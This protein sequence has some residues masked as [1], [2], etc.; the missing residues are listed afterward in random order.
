MKDTLPPYSVADGLRVDSRHRYT[1]RRSRALRLLAFGCLAFVAYT[2]WFQLRRD[3]WSPES[4]PV[5]L[6]LERLQ[7]DVATCSKLRHK[8]ADPSGPRDRNARYVDGHDP[9]LIRNATVWVGEPIQ[10]TTVEEARL[11]KG[12]GW[13]KSDILLQNGLILR[14]EP[15]ILENGLPTGTQIWNAYGRQLTAGIV[16][17]HSHTGLFTLPSLRGDSDVNELSNDITPF[18]RAIDALNPLDPQLEVIKSGGVTTSLVLPGSGNNIGGEAYIIKHAVGPKDGRPEISAKDLLADPE[19]NWRYMKMACGE[20]PKGVY[21]ERGH[22]HGPFSRLGESWYFRHAF[23]EAREL[24]HAQDDW[25]NAAHETGV[26]NLK[27]YLPQ[28]LRLESLGAVLRGQV[29]VNTHCYTIPDIEA[30]IDHTNEFEFP[31]R[32]FHHA[33]Q[34]YL[35]PEASLPIIASASLPVLSYLGTQTS[36]G[37]KTTCCRPLR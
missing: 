25:C 27:S 29:H 23:E 31:V 1:V 7:A 14:V 36:M 12:Y 18:V 35:V 10:G 6:S 28:E 8:P 17:M 37:W 16:D 22:G 20:N 33:H 3:Y 9:T 19:Q 32:A 15:E 2:Q 34:A 5:G 24:V 11:G 4:H 30:F 21:G 26:E 13:V